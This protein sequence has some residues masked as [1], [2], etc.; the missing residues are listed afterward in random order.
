MHMTH[1]TQDTAKAR[2]TYITIKC[3]SPGKHYSCIPFPFRF[4]GQC[5]GN[6][7][8]C[9]PKQCL[10]YSI[11]TTSNS[12]Q[13]E[14]KA[15]KQP[16]LDMIQQCN[17]KNRTVTSTDRDC[18]MVPTTRVMGHLTHVKPKIAPVGDHR[19]LALRTKVIKTRNM[20]SIQSSK[21]WN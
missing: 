21:P 14:G 16:V 12:T 19:Q 3:E 2:Y 6:P 1:M 13:L 7:F 4:E 18:L 5:K 17:N 8:L 11:A 9:L 20:E 10:T 15:A